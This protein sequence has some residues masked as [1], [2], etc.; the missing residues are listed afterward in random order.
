MS[1][2]EPHEIDC[3]DVLAQVF[4]YLDGEMTDDRHARI[5]EHLD[6][7]SPVPA[8]VR[9]RAGVQGAG[10]ALLRRRRGRRTR[11]A[12]KVRGPAARGGRDR[13]HARWSSTG[14]TDRR[15]PSPARR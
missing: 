7:C 4:L 9:H 15:T 10:G 12:D 3:D 5:R 13:D 1:C 14:S 8:Q 2:G 6:D 11:C